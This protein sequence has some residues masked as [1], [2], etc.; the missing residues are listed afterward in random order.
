V[1]AK[2]DLVQGEFVCEAGSLVGFHTDLEQ[3]ALEISDCELLCRSKKFCNFFWR[4]TVLST[5]QCR[6]YRQCADL[7]REPGAVGSLMA[8]GDATKTLCRIANP[9]V[10]WKVS[11]RREFLG[12]QVI[13][14]PPFGRC[15]FEDIVQQCDHKLLIGGIGVEKCARCEFAEA[16]TLPEFA[17][18][19]KRPLYKRYEHGQ[20]V[21]ASCWMERF[22]T[23]P[24]A[25]AGLM[26]CVSGTW[27]DPAGSFGLS[28][29]TCEACIQVVDAKYADLDMQGVQEL[30][31]VDRQEVTLFIDG[32]NRKFLDNNILDNNIKE[33]WFYL[34]HEAG[35]P[36]RCGRPNKLLCASRDDANCMWGQFPKGM[37]YDQVPG[38]V[39]PRPYEVA[40]PGW[41][42]RDGSDACKYLGCYK[43]VPPSPQPTP[44]PTKTGE[45]TTHI[46]G[47][48]A[49]SEQDEQ[50]SCSNA[51]DGNLNGFATKYESVGGW[52]T[53]EL[54]SEYVITEF[55]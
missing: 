54:D 4:G 17:W 38:V 23:F 42:P 45:V 15:E 28:S 33:T 18:S 39:S 10:C 3:E 51:Y 40:C 24:A 31:F 46:I 30:F 27:L 11:K 7:V 2:V 20:Q 5:V 22:S 32:G 50:W 55:E 26:T 52:I 29:F 48:H 8:L 16:D 14:N 44:A 36:V 37:N 34:D 13:S 19:H 12:A 25:N 49:S 43:D 35:V 53:L 21:K 1:P 6:L 47:C 41:R 9:E